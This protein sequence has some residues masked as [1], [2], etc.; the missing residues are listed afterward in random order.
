MEKVTSD[1]IGQRKLRINNLN[2]LRELGINPFPSV[3]NKDCKNIEVKNN[4]AKVKGTEI[5]L[6]G[7]LTS[8][9]E[10]GKILFGDIQDESGKIQ[11]AVKQDE[12]VSDKQKSYLSF[13]NLNLIDIGDF[14][15]IYGKVEKT[16]QGEVTIFVKHI[17]LLAKC[18]RPLPIKFDEKEEQFRRRYLDLIVN[19]VR[20]ELFKRKS[21]FW[22][23]SR[24]FMNKNGFMEV[25]TPVLEHV[26]GGAD[27]NPFVTYHNVLDQNFYLRI[28]TE[29]YQK[30]LIGA[31]FEKIFTLG[32]NFRN[33]GSSDEHLQEF[34]QIEWYW[35]YANYKDNMTLVKNWFRHLAKTIYG[36]TKFN[37][38]GY[39][40]DLADDWKEIDY[41]K[42]IKST[43]GVDIFTDSD[44][45]IL[46]ILKEN[47]VRLPGNINRLRLIDNLW[48]LIR[49]TISGPAFLVNEP[50]FMS[51]LA[52]AKQEDPRITERYHV[53]IAGSELGNGYS[54][55]NDPQYQ[56]A[57]FLDQQ[58]M[59]DLGD[60]EAQMLDIDF[61]EMLEYGM[62]PTSGHGSS[63]R[64]FWFFENISGK[65]GTLFP[66]MKHEIEKITK[67]L[68]PDVKFETQ[69][70]KIKKQSSQSDVDLSGMPSIEQATQLLQKHVKEPYQLL[71]SKMVA[72]AMK[73]YSK[74]YGE[75]E[76]LWYITG[77]MHDLDY[78]EFPNEH[79]KYSIEWLEELK[80]PKE[81][82]YSISAHAYS[83]KRTDTPPKST[84][85]FALIACDELSGLLYA[86]SLMR[87]TGFI[88]MEAKSAIKKF[89]D[90]AF[91][92]KVDRNEITTGVDG[93]GLDL[94]EHIQKLISVFQTIDELKK[95]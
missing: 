6:S 77:L 44:T 1:F 55:I 93:L 88:G 47:G 73:M 37:S 62:P 10:H 12:L 35:A 52:K 85:D 54:E 48:K 66:Q 56:L 76:N 92:A 23:E 81:L 80:Y 3:S 61:V 49:K 17:K 21:L 41:V 28:S 64:V 13:E 90:K 57:Q 67:T 58:K 2:K 24:N 42:I 20:K 79:P 7:R 60:E 71:H 83:T 94:K 8:K 87:P 53:I 16:Q 26:T 50:A 84:M 25:E 95:T 75:N 63:E 46:Q 9:R 32:P 14:L 59:R 43:Y 45:K 68:Y 36:K 78:N 40:F 89:K 5:T 39:S 19:P 51:P 31:G 4:F 65:E 34:Y 22:Q 86:Y 70:S 15:E 33:E 91:A 82:I 29:L 27:A 18:L 30:R 72:S 38:R 69:K 74:E 11:F